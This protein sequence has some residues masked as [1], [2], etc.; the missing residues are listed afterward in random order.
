MTYVEDIIMDLAGLD[1]TLGIFSVK[2]PF[3]VSPYD[4]T[5]IVSFANSLIERR[6]L[7]EPQRK[8]ALKVLSKHKS[9]LA[10]SYNLDVDAFF[11]NPL[12]RNAVR[13]IDKT[14][15]IY[16]KED[17]IHLK[18]PY[19]QEVVDKI[20]LLGRS[21]THFDLYSYDGTNKEYIFSMVEKNIKFLASNFNEF[22]K[23]PLILDLY[24]QI[25]Q[26][27][28]QPEKYVPMLCLENNQFVYKNAHPSMPAPS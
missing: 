27:E 10:N 25:K 3:E 21:R 24:E 15:K 19:D 23:D 22:E 20:K 17:K 1:R 18:S 7:T 2:K 8:L 11:S 26:I 12:W 14:K 5:Y 6:P 28:I 4:F 16:I 9:N 13:V